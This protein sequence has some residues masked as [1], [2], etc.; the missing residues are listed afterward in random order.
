MAKMQIDFADMGGVPV[1]TSNT[2]YIA[3]GATD[4]VADDD[5]ASVVVI[6]GANSTPTVKLNDVT[7]TVERFATT[8]FYG[9]ILYDIKKN[10]VIS[11]TGY[12]FI[13]TNKL[14]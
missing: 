10:D 9:T 2:T 7:Q 3:S 13:T 6:V 8:V 12:K 1:L 4:Y 14:S 11:A 5:Y